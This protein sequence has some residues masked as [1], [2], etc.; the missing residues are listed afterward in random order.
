MSP[1][2]RRLLRHALSGI[3]LGVGTAGCLDASDPGSTPDPPSG[4]DPSTGTETDPPVRTPRNPGG[5]SVL[6]EA[7]ATETAST[8]SPAETGTGSTS[9]PAAGPPAGA[10]PGAIRQE[11]IVDADRV[12]ELAFA[13][14]VPAEAAASARSFLTATDFETQSVFFRTLGIESCK[15]YRIH[16]VSWEGDHVEFEYCRE[17]RPPDR[18]CTA[19]TWDAVGLFIRLPVTFRSPT[20]LSGSGASGRS[21]CRDVDT[22]YDRLD[23]NATVEGSPVVVDSDADSTDRSPTGSDPTD[24][25]TVTVGTS[26]T[27]GTP[28][29][30]NSLDASET[31]GASDAPNLSSVSD[32]GDGS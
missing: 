20:A 8:G 27:T 3:A 11:L 32:G 13:D 31:S 4:P 2:R 6:R 17:L 16:S 1:S 24:S 5:Q 30:S 25:A 15:R 14:G 21:P 12:A 29:A 26:T 9:R 19:D 10:V 7:S 28:D 23:A 22:T 18:S